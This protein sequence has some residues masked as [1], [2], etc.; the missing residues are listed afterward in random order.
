MEKQNFI[1]EDNP[2]SKTEEDCLNYTHFANN[3]YNLISNI[4]KRKILLILQ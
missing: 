1:L 2:I 3:I 4:S